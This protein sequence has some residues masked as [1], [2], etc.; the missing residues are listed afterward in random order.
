MTRTA[1]KRIINPGALYRIALIIVLG[2]GL[3]WTAACGGEEGGA[4]T[5]AP[6]ETTAASDTVTS[7]ATTSSGATT[8]SASAP[9]AKLDKLT[10]VAPPGPMAIPMAYMAINN[11][12]SSVAEKTEV[13]MWQN[14]DQ[15]KAMVAGKQGD[16]VTIPSNNSAIFYNK[17]LV[18]KL[19]DISVWNITY[20]VTNDPDAASLT[21]VKGESMVVSLKGSVADVMYQYLATKEGLDPAKDFQL[22]YVPDPQQAAQLLLSG[23]ADNA[24]LSEALATSV[25]LQTKDKKKPFRRA[26]AFGKAWAAASG[27]TG[28]ASLTPIAG[29]C[30]TASVL[31]KP[32]VIEA[33]V[34]EYAKAV[35]WMLAN[36]EAAGTLVEIE[37]PELGLKAA[38][39]TAALK[40]ITWKFTTAAEARPSL[41]A[42]YQTLSELSPEVIG[43]KLP[44]DGFYY[45]S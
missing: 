27:G 42:F 3:L 15:L 14:A 29:T 43:G 36:P 20:L 44:D 12:L 41:E 1:S 22:R 31:D 19:L 26:M 10:L 4:T 30:A 40:S 16:F 13:V 45:G 25:I 28:A 23:Q 38:P 11:A 7:L 32:E 17:G 37:L 9:T 35:E 2:V 21:D 8:T 24:I 33:F 34:T 5:T 6:V 18:L 39:M